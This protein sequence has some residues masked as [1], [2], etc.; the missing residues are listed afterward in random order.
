MYHLKDLATEEKASIH[1]L[2]TMFK[3]ALETLFIT[4]CLPVKYIGEEDSSV[5]T[6]LSQ[7]TTDLFNALGGFNAN[8]ENYLECQ[9]VAILGPW[10]LL[11]LNSTE[12]IDQCKD[13]LLDVVEKFSNLRGKPD[14]FKVFMKNIQADIR[15]IVY[16]GGILSREPTIVEGLYRYYTEYKDILLDD[17]DFTELSNVCTAL[18]FSDCPMSFEICK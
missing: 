6:F 17:G 8:P 15:P 12:A 16:I 13:L 5:E 18:M 9:L 3:D 7:W 1:Y 10:Q 2:Y 14:A 4:S 11:V